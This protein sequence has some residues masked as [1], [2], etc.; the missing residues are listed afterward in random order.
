MNKIK[1]IIKSIIK[2]PYASLLICWYGYVRWIMLPL[3]NA[4]SIL[5]GQNQFGAFIAILSGV[6]L[7]Y[8]II[9]DIPKGIY[10]SI[11]LITTM[12]LGMFNVWCLYGMTGIYVKDMSLI[13]V[14]YMILDISIL[15]FYILMLN[16]CLMTI[17]NTVC[18][19]ID[20]R[21]KLIGI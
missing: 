17:K 10:S 1:L 16:K 5:W 6:Y 12:G 15:T 3:T 8:Y 2:H 19:Y 7:G 13:N 11:W 21:I 18:D 14:G 9:K 20:A 4:E